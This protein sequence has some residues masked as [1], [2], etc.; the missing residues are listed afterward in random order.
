M[1]M[2]LKDAISIVDSL[3]T[4]DEYS[5]PFWL[6]LAIPIYFVFI[7]K[8]VSDG[9]AGDVPKTFA[10][11]IIGFFSL[12]KVNSFVIFISAILFVWG[13]CRIV[14]GNE[15]KQR[16][17]DLGWRLK[18]NFL[19]Y[20]YYKSDTTNICNNISIT[21]DELKKITNMYPKEFSF[22]DRKTI[23]LT[24]SLYRMNIFKNCEKQLHAYLSNPDVPYG[25]PIPF[26]ELYNKC[27]NFTIP[28]V[29]KLIQDSGKKYSF[30]STKIMRKPD[31]IVVF[32]II[33][34]ASI[35]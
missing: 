5:L 4:L 35:K 18:G 19:L 26:Q 27:D 20:N 13:A 34:L 24:D 12:P 7:K 32:K 11:K 9:D 10:Q 25:T 22:V 30:I 2:Q 29:F 23:V 1:D 33:K 17:R 31:S 21:V 6:S 3:K 14:K 28:V 15:E 8:I 16:I